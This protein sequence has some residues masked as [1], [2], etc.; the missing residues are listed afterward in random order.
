M[1]APACGCPQ[2]VVNLVEVLAPLAVH[3]REQDTTF[4]VPPPIGAADLASPC[5]VGL[6]R[7]VPTWPTPSLAPSIAWG[8]DDATEP[9][10]RKRAARDF[11][12]QGY[13]AWSKGCPTQRW[14]RVCSSGCQR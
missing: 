9:P 13:S 7:S 5:G 6:R 1:R 10:L 8:C 3:D 14:P 2:H 4:K 12:M 11:I